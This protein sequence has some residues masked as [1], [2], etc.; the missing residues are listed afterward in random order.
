MGA[1]SRSRDVSAPWQRATFVWMLI[2]L[3]EALQGTAR[4]IWL[5]PLLGGLRARQIAIVTG[6]IIIFAVAWLTVRWIAA[7]SRREWWLVGAL[8]VALTI[9]FEIALGRI[10]GLGWPRIAADYNPTAGGFM[11][12]GLAF[13]ACA[14]LLAARLRR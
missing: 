14:P 7:R 9:S 12:V 4:E 13:M 11:L 6:C 10:L 2:T 3:L 8:W 5:A 1:R